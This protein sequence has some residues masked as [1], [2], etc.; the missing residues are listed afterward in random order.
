MT[1]GRAHHPPFRRFIAELLGIAALSVAIATGLSGP[2]TLVGAPGRPA[3]V[4]GAMPADTDHVVLAAPAGTPLYQDSLTEPLVVR[5]VNGVLTATLDITYQHLAVT[6]ASGTVSM[7]LRAYTLAATTDPAYRPGD[8][9]FTP[10]F[11]GPTFRVRP[12][13][14]V[15][16]TLRNRLPPPDDSTD[17]NTR[18]MDYGATKKDPTGLPLDV[19]QNC[20]H[21][22]NYTNIHY[23]GMHVTPDSTGSI[24][25]DD[26]LLAVAPGDSIQY[27]FRIPLNQSPGTHWYHPHKHG[28]VALQVLNGMAGA[29]IVEDPSRGLDSL[30][31]A[32]NLREYLIAFQQI[33]TILGLFTGTSA[34]RTESPLVNGQ[35]D[36]VIYMA[37]GEVQRWRIVNENITRNTKTLEFRFQNRPGDEPG[38]WDVAR[39]GVQFAPGNYSQQ[40][41]SVLLMS[42]GNRLDV[43]VQAPRTP[44]THH[45]RIRHL[46]GA[47]QETRR[48]MLPLQT[49]A[50]PSSPQ[51][52]DTNS[53]VLFRVVVDPSRTNTSRGRPASLPELPPFLQGKLPAARDTAV[54]VF[55]DTLKKQP[56]QFYMGSVTEP[57]Q[58]FNDTVV[59]VPSNSRGT[60]LPMR[61]DSIQTWKIVNRSQQQISHPFH[62][63][64]NPFQVDS[65]Y[66][67]MG[68]RDPYYALFQQLNTAA[69]NGSPIWLDVI[70]LPIPTVDSVMVDD[71]AQIYV[72]DPGHVFITQ[73]YDAF[74][75]CTDGSCG[76][77][78]GNFVMHCHILGH[79][80]R[81]M[82]QVLQVSEPGQPVSPPR[83]HAGD[84]HGAHPAAG[85]GG[86]RGSGRGQNPPGQQRH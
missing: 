55:T 80:E 71:T 16:I 8:P 84:G 19:Y 52:A 24:V 27:H 43:F 29:F 26:V 7:P 78:T 83:S 42:P 75:G 18:C 63:H 49:L 23:H 77:P 59:F 53:W 45:M 73:R 60:P 33:D 25:G 30:A 6:H 66:A 21:G 51:A 15:R 2:R 3:A 72:K 61:L 74:T 44:G 35:N 32:Y 14:L 56:T 37:P 39:D 79:E 17:F 11:P 50:S 40:S 67:P 4:E 48:P 82:M 36:P 41:D 86:G 62:I 64:I 22:P 34:A 65:V 69:R 70:P 68:E 47:G 5:S 12:G 28:S 9:R 58:R 20:F 10:R 13:D 46:P 76:P 85:A 1:R 54:I 31:N 81:G 57:Y 38:L